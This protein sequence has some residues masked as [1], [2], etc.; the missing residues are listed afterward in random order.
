MNNATC[1][2]RYKIPCGELRAEQ[3]IRL[4]IDTEQLPKDE[5]ELNRMRCHKRKQKAEI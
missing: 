5:E 1:K 2:E 4:E 3:Q